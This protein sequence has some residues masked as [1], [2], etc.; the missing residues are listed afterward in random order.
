MKY[1][2]SLKVVSVLLDCK[3]LKNVVIST[4]NS[5]QVEKTSVCVCFVSVY[6]LPP[7]LLLSF[8]SYTC[9][10][11]LLWQAVNSPKSP[12]VGTSVCLPWCY[13]CPEQPR[14][15]MSSSGVSPQ[16]TPPSLRC[17]KSP[18]VWHLI[19]ISPTVVMLK[20]SRLFK[21]ITENLFNEG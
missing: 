16:M 19:L 8:P 5:T 4:V 1:R 14:Q 9:R 18:E 20:L 2:G 6:K 7:L 3:L 15:T 12:F 17:V 10:S 13:G 11:T 21:T